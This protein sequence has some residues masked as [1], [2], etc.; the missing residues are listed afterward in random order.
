MLGATHACIVEGHF[1][2][3]IF[4]WFIAGYSHDM[5]YQH[6]NGF[7][8]S[9]ECQPVATV[10]GFPGHGIGGSDS[11]DYGGDDRE[12]DSDDSSRNSTP[13]RQLTV[14]K[15]ACCGDY[16]FRKPYHVDNGVK[17]CCGEVPY[18][19]E[20]MQ[21]CPGEIARMICD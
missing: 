13:P 21:C 6:K 18:N 8:P 15:R 14:P 16:P 19:T 4:Q 11:N 5:S 20:F 7:D 1:V 10:D 2:I 12:S 3:N 17:K 9:L